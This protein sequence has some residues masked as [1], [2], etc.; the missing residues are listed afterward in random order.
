V[1]FVLVGDKDRGRLV[2]ERREGA[3]Q[4]MGRFGFIFK[5]ASLLL[6]KFFF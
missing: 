2:H 3:S 5:L 1:G 6:F 4:M